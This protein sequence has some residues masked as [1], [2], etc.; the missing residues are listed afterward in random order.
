[1]L[2]LAEIVQLKLDPGS[3]P[4]CVSLGGLLNPSG[5]RIP[6]L[7]KRMSDTYLV[8]SLRGLSERRN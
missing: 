6:Q 5:P 2:H 4:Y 1:M 3:A 7:A 8:A